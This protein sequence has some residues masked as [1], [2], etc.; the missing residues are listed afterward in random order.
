MSFQLVSSGH[1]N[2][3][4]RDSVVLR[5]LAERLER[6]PDLTDGVLNHPQ[7]NLGD[8]YRE[9][10]EVFGV[11]LKPR[12]RWGGCKTLREPLWLPLKS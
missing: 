4:K 10:A 11:S 1:G 7:S 8:G 2:L 3:S 9:L 5:A 12:N 6:Q